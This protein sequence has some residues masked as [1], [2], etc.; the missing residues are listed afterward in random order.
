[1][2]HTYVLHIPG[3]KVLGVF[4]SYGDATRARDSLPL[5]EN[6][7]AV[8]AP[9]MSF[10]PGERFH[11]HPTMGEFQPSFRTNTNP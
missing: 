7:T 3:D 8:I 5:V 2:K 1:M 10:L 11:Y 6:V 4:D 9:T